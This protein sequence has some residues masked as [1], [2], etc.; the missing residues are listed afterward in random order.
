MKRKSVYKAIE[1]FKLLDDFIVNYMIAFGA[2]L[3]LLLNFA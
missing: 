1:T 3:L 2:V